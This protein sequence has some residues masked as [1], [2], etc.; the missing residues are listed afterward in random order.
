[1][2]ETNY[3]IL[4]SVY[5]KDHPLWL[6]EAID[7]MLN[8]TLKSNEF[9][10][11]KDGP[12]TKE[13]DIVINQYQNEYPNIFKII[14]LEKN[15][16]LGPALAKGVLACSN[17]FIARMDADD[18]A[19]LNRC[20]LELEKIIEDKLDIVGSMTIEF[21]DSIDKV[22]SIRNLPESND[23]IYQFAKRRNPFCHPSVMINKESLLFAGNYR[24]FHLC[25]DYD[26]WVRM[27]Y[28]NAKCYNFQ[29]P[30]TYM[31]INKDFY[32]RRGGLKYLKSILKFKYYCY[33]INFFSF[34]DFFI[35]SLASIV[36][37]TIP[38]PLR[39]LIYK[40]LL[41]KANYK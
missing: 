41:R 23:E 7:S 27:L 11:V 31:R 14:S 37:C 12:L 30:L 40:K 26:M 36:V 21:T 9:V 39:V 3:S 15:V 28:K 10:I 35:S 16:G 22:V 2:A 38:S 19:D 32:S 25:E 24:E 6:K 34:N 13:L 1:M 33:K 4:M 18:V 17:S 8:Q 20:K 29:I 5:S